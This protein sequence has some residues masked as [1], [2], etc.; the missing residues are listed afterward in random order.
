VRGVRIAQRLPLNVQV[1]GT[2]RAFFK[3]DLVCSCTVERLSIAISGSCEFRLRWVSEHNV[4]TEEVY[5]G[6]PHMWVAV[7]PSEYWPKK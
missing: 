1:P 7:A 6:D 2:K 4:P 3:G 5:Y